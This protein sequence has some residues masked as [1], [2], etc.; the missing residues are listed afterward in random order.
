MEN[1]TQEYVTDIVGLKNQ[2]ATRRAR[3]LKKGK[4]RHERRNED[5][6]NRGK[7][8]PKSTVTK[9]N[10]SGPLSGDDNRDKKIGRNRTD[11][12]LALAEIREAERNL[13]VR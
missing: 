9:T 8:P 1:K 6:R 13:R 4:E 10:P 12:G 7:N 5:C 11:K 3:S 2:T